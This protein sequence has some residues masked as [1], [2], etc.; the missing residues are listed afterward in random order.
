MLCSHN[1]TKETTKDGKKTLIILRKISKDTLVYTIT[2]G[3]PNTDYFLKT[4]NHFTYCE[5]S[6]RSLIFYKIYSHCGYGFKS[7]NYMNA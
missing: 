3:D 2:N 5:K 1:T 6:E 7:L 4:Q